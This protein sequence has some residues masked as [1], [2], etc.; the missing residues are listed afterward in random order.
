MLNDHIKTYRKAKHL[1]QEEMAV[2]LHVVRQTVSKWETGVSVP[3]AEMLIR[4]AQ[5]LDVPVSRLLGLEA[6]APDAQE[7]AGELARLNEE[8]A[9]KNRAEALHRQA[10]KKTGLILLLSFAA[11]LATLAV[12]NA[13][14]SLVLSGGCMLLAVIILYRNLALLSSVTTQDLRLPILRLTTLFNI[15]FLCVCLLLSVLTGTGILRFS[16]LAE[17]ALAVFLVSGLMI[18]TGI[19]A[20]RL[21]FTRHTGLRLP[22]TVQDEQTWNLAHRILGQISVPLAL[23]Y[24]GCAA[25]VDDFET[26]TLL[27][28]VL[29]VGIPGAVSGLF[30]WRKIHGR[31]TPPEP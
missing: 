31:Q 13:V 2:R 20:P 26:V 5:L 18:F 14:F 16:A 29:W 3:D 27:A 19:V 7:L 8:L 21:P 6:E 30:F 11:M 1:S 12:D 28:I 15:G 4:I 24:I 9:R 25:T 22:W 23:V 17:K 10:G